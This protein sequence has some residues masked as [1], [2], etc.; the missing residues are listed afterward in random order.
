[1]NKEGKGRKQR[2]SG[3][4]KKVFFIIALFSLLVLGI[5]SAFMYVRVGIGVNKGKIGYCMQDEK[6]VITWQTVSD[7]KAYRL[8]R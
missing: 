6:L 1:M 5:A 7:K 3:R 2:K 8:S 4:E